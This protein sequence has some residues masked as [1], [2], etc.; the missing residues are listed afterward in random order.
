MSV[1]VSDMH[2][3]VSVCEKI[4]NDKFE[5]GNNTSNKTFVLD[6]QFFFFP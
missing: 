1:H 4:E 3:C 6:Y 2:M 5:D